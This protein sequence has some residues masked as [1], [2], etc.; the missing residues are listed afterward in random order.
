MF[1][2]QSYYERLLHGLLLSTKGHDELSRGFTAVTL[3]V[4]HGK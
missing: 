3:L 2:C 1:S 4:L